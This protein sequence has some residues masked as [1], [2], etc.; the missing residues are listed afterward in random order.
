VASAVL[1]LG[2]SSPPAHVALALG[3]TVVVALVVMRAPLHR[4][5]RLKPGDA[6]RHA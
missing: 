6:L 2:S 4:A 3:A 5:V 1:P